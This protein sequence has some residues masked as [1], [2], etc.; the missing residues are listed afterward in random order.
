MKMEFD[1]FEML[2]DESENTIYFKGVLRSNEFEQFDKIKN[3]ILDIYGLEISELVMN[4]GDL[5]FMNSSGISTLCRVIIDAKESG[6]NKPI[7]I[8]GKKDILWQ[9]K[10]FENLKKIWDL[11]SLEFN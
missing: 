7:R 10:S 5:E 4:F 3:F 6:V 11:I 1:N 9:V 8:L 2:F